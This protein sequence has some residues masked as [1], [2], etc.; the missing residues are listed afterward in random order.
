MPDFNRF[1]RLLSGLGLF[2]SGGIVGS[3]VFLSL[4]HHTYNVLVIDNLNLRKENSE[5]QLDIE[6]LNKFRN[7]QGLITHVTV[8]LYNSVQHPLESH[9]EKAIEDRV[10]RDLKIVEG[11]KVGEIRDS[12]QLYERLITNKTYYGVVD[13]D[14]IVNVKSMVLVQSELT[15]WITAEEPRKLPAPDKGTNAPGGDS[16]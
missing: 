9:V 2:I 3:A 16:F 10:K 6:S 1:P 11:Q 8:H 15:V 13:K 4:Y 12:P 5:L 7:K 14:Y